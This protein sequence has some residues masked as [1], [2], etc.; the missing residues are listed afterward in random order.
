MPNHDAASSAPHVLAHHA[1]L[2]H[3]LSLMC[4]PAHTLHGDTRMAPRE[5]E[6][7]PGKKCAHGYRSGALL[8]NHDV[9]SVRTSPLWHVAGAGSKHR[10]R[11]ASMLCHGVHGVL[12]VV[13]GTA[14]FSTPLCAL[15]P[16]SCTAR[17][18]PCRKRVRSMLSP[19]LGQHAAVEVHVHTFR[20]YTHGGRR[21]RTHARTYLHTRRGTHATCS[22][23]RT[24]A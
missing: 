18:T 8:Q 1:M 11:T 21:T 6:P 16:S 23:F 9:W 17:R 2:P 3:R 15:R 10:C 14:P 5:I 24:L 13:G 22:R 20:A 7:Q 4:T 19:A 12:G